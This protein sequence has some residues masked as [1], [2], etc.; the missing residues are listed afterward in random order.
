MSLTKN[1][2]VK[3]FAIENG[4]PLNQSVELI[5]ALLELIKSILAY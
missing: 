2:I 5:E 1:D 3:A 4:Y